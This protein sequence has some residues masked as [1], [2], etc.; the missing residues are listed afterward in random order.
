MSDSSWVSISSEQLFKKYSVYDGPVNYPLY[1]YFRGNISSCCAVQC[2]TPFRYAASV[3]S[4]ILSSF[5][6]YLSLL[7]NASSTEDKFSF[8]IF[9]YSNVGD[10]IQAKAM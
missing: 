6:S 2:R 9:T 4:V 1:G 5:L 10:R 8:Y 3:L 7:Y